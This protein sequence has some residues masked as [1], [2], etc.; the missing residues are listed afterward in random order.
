MLRAT[1]RTKGS[2]KKYNGITLKALLSSPVQTVSKDDPTGLNKHEVL[3]SVA[4]YLG[5]SPTGR[6]HPKS[7]R[8]GYPYF[9]MY[10]FAGVCCVTLGRRPGCHPNSTDPFAFFI[11]VACGYLIFTPLVPSRAAMYGP[12]LLFFGYHARNAEKVVASRCPSLLSSWYLRRCFDFGFI[13]IPSDLTSDP[14]TI[15]Q[16]RKDPH[17]KQTILI[18]FFYSLVSMARRS[19]ASAGLV[20]T[21]GKKTVG[22]STTGGT[23][24]RFSVKPDLHDRPRSSLFSPSSNHG[25]S[26]VVS[27]F[28]FIASPDRS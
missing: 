1:F 17:V 19:Q 25:M 24:H 13:S 22:P 21:K 4:P 14:F 3:E 11:H 20:E 12:Y 7:C 15:A 23:C 28:R 6:P 2:S 27:A 16:R 9:R 10:V 8:R 18:S 5:I 26:A